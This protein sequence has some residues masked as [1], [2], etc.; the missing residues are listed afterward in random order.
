MA[1]Q[2]WDTATAP[3][4]A[5]GP[6]ARVLVVDDEPSMRQML[7]FALRREGYDVTTADDGRTALEALRDGR[8]DLVV[9]DVRM[10]EVSG[11]D[12]LREAKRLDPALSI[13]MMTAYGSKETVLEALRLGA[14]DYVEKTPNLRDELTLRVRKELDR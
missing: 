6:T 14:T 12:L 8:F 9:T 3:V 4:V 7:S 5:A 1:E 13:I 2:M 10:P 11:V